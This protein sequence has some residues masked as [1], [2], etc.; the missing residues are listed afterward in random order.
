M[1]EPVS[2]PHIPVKNQEGYLSCEG[3]PQEQV[4]PVPYQAPQLRVLVLERE[5]PIN[6]GCENEQELWLKALWLGG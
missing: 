4:V 5:A 2:H 3:L 6:S 1:N